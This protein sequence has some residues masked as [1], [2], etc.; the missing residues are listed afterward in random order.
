MAQGKL[1]SI[2]VLAQA[3]FGAVAVVV[4]R[5][6]FRSWPAGSYTWIPG[7]IGLAGLVLLVTLGYELA[8]HGLALPLVA[9]AW[10]VGRVAGVI[11]A[12][13]VPGVGVDA[14]LLATATFGF[15][16]AN[17]QGVTI[18]VPTLVPLVVQL[19][20][21]SLAWLWGRRN[22]RLQGSGASS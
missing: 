17:T 11:V 10:L 3:A 1:F 19:T 21:L 18:G 9:A 7:L 13:A 14:S 22:R 16:I 4:I 15:L 5:W 8:V 12:A 2:G 6:G 20:A